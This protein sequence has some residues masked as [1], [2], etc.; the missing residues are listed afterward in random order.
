VISAILKLRRRHD[1]DVYAC[2]FSYCCDPLCNCRFSRNCYRIY[3]YIY[4]YVIQIL[5]R[6]RYENVEHVRFV[7][8]FRIRVLIFEISPKLAVGLYF[9]FRTF[10]VTVCAVATTMNMQLAGR[11]VH[12]PLRTTNK[13]RLVS[14]R[15]SGRRNSVLYE[16]LRNT[17]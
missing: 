15:N 5:S 16:K 9:R 8:I 13:T 11:L 12:S 3:I 6:R 14:R 7:G 2:V 4:T 17:R 10:L 1:A